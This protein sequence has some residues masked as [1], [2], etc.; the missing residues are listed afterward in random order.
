MT[1][2]IHQIIMNHVAF[3]SVRITEDVSMLNFLTSHIAIIH[4]QRLVIEENRNQTSNNP[5]STKSTNAVILANAANQ[6]NSHAIKIY[7]NKSF[8]SFNSFLF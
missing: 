7:L 6:K 3:E 5:N 4:N 1:A 2:I 8:L